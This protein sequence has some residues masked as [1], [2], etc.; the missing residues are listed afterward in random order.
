MLID[1]DA[2]GFPDDW[3][4]GVH[5]RRG[6]RRVPPPAESDPEQRLREH[7]AGDRGRTRRERIMGRL[8]E[9]DRGLLAVGDDTPVGAA[10]IALTTGAEPLVDAWVAR[11]GVPFAVSA[12]GEAFRLVDS[13]ALWRSRD[14]GFERLWR[15]EDFGRAWAVARQ[16]RRH[17]AAAPD[18]VDAILAGFRTWPAGR[19]LT[20][21]LMPTRVDWVDEDCAAAAGWDE[22]PEEWQW[23]DHRHLRSALVLAAGHTG[24]LELLRDAIT[25]AMLG[26]RDLGAVATVLDGV[27]PSAVEYLAE[28]FYLRLFRLL[29]D[30]SDNRERLGEPAIRIMAATPDDDAMRILLRHTL[31]GERP[32][33]GQLLRSGAMRRY[34]ARALRVLAE[35]DDAVSR[36]LAGAIVLDR[37]ELA[38]ALAEPVRAGLGSGWAALLDANARHRPLDSAD[39]VKRAVGAL[40]AIP[41]EEAFGLV[42]DR[43]ERKYFRQALLAAAKRAPDRAVRVLAA[44]DTDPAVSELLRD[45]VLRYPASLAALDETDRARV[46]AR[47]GVPARTAVAG[48]VPSPGGVTSAGRVPAVLAPASRAGGLPEWLVPARL[49]AVT[50][51]DGGEVLAP[52]AVRRL[53][54]LLAASRIGRMKPEIDQVRQLGDFAAFAWEIFEQWRAADCPPKTTLAMTA[55]AAFGD[56]TTVRDLIALL[57]GWS[58]VSSR[59]RAGMDVL[60]AIGTDAALT[61]L[62]RLSRTARTAGFRRA[63]TVR[64]TA[65]AEGRGLRPEQLADRILPDFGLDADGR[66]TLDYGSRRFTVGFDEQ[67]QPWI[68][69][70]TGRRLTRLPRPTDDVSTAA[71]KRFAE[72]KKEAKTVGAD[73]VRAMEAAM[74]T[75]RRWTPE[76]FRR[77]LIGHPL[78]WQLTHRLLWAAFD[79]DT[80]VVDAGAAFQ[81]G[82]AGVTVFRIAEDRTLADLDDKQW[83]L[84]EGATVGVA[85]PWHFAGD[86]AVWASLFADYAIIQPFPQV[87]R[88][89]TGRSEADVPAFTGRPVQGRRLFVLSAR[90][91]Q[92]SDGHHSLLRDFP[93]GHTVEIGYSPG[94]HWQEPDLPKQFD[95]V[96]GLDDLGPIAFSEV[97]RDIRYLT[98]P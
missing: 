24:H 92:F 18:D 71:H 95:G 60:A 58:S 55:L 51:R 88:E 42:L 14:G 50:L 49:P 23:A 26:Y 38:P 36:D 37:P 12:V 81:G 25:D 61:Q 7:L 93:G 97:I 44:R 17:L 73:R 34:P 89:L 13:G 19:I 54:Q 1:E 9:Y 91:W 8:I 53:C 3:W 29:D 46:R 76:E 35:R 83:T 4:H 68:A 57:P 96:T 87:G 30:G 15:S 94:Y 80:M 43:V 11:F 78:A 5:P 59:V 66:T 16:V 48:A 32:R 74:V 72:M 22:G 98:G 39:D 20:S 56:D 6:G 45:H 69:D 62:D 65:A 63:A 41:T 64:L 67:L 70:A 79:G 85:H 77:H 82:R 75:G 84:P 10:V 33:P 27:G 21:Y 47:I 31:D 28:P 40:A 90:G 86:R 52:E 2:W